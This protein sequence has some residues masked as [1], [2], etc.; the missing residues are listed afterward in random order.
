MGGFGTKG[1]FTRGRF[2]FSLLAF[3]FLAS[4][5]FVAPWGPA[6]PRARAGESLAR[7][8]EG[9]VA[10]ELPEFDLNSIVDRTEMQ[11]CNTTFKLVSNV[12]GFPDYESL[13]TLHD[14]GTVRFYAGMVSKGLGAW[15]VI[16]GDPDEGEDPNDLFIEWTQPLTD[17]YKDAFIVPGG[18]DL[19]NQSRISVIWCG[20]GTVTCITNRDILCRTETKR[21]AREAFERAL[22]T[23]KAETSGFKTPARI[24]GAGG[25]RVKKALPGTSI[26]GK[27]DKASDPCKHFC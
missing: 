18:R 23:P 21:K 9:L 3:V 8:A 22:T 6:S 2:Q 24:A 17:A 10:T 11:L 20:L 25:T 16:E 14:N 19:V 26:G 4:R 7:P 13:L 5:C 1:R 15:S 27:L 12:F